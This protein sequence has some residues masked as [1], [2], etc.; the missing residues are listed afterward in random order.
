[1]LD[2]ME[3]EGVKSSQRIKYSNLFCRYC[4]GVPCQ[5]HIANP[6]LLIAKLNKLNI[7]F[8]KRFDSIL[9]ICHCKRSIVYQIKL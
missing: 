5:F 1:M 3:R 2:E 4:G 8:L 6:D 7:C 9:A